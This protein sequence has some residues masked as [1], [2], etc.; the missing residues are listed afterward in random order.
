MG[1]DESKQEN[2]SRAHI[3][4]YIPRKSLT[5]ERRSSE[6]QT[7]FLLRK[8]EL[9]LALADVKKG[10]VASEIKIY[11]KNSDVEKESFWHRCTLL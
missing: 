8:A 9:D 1:R 10:P 4:P 7:S 3:Q 6:I 11:P 5:R 2:K